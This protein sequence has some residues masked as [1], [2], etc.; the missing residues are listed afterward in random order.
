ME[1][2]VTDHHS[3]RR[4]AEGND[5]LPPAFAVINPKRQGD[6]PAFVELAGVG[7][8]Y[9][10]AQ[11]LLLEASPGGDLPGDP[12]LLDLVAIGTV[13]DV[14]PL[15][16]GGENRRLVKEGLALLGRP[17]RPGIQA[18]MAEAR[19][20]P[21]HV[22]AVDIGFV[23]GPRIN[24]AGRLESAMLAYDL[25]TAPD[26]LTARELAAALGALNR[27]RQALTHELAAR[28]KEKIA[29]EG[30][31]R[32][33]YLVSDPEFPSGIVGLVA[34]RLVEEL[35]RPVMLVEEDQN[36]SGNSRGSARSIPE[37]NVTAALDECREL[38]VRHG[39]H[40]MAAG[41]T[42][43]NALLP[44]LRARLEAI[45]QRELGG[46]DLVPTLRIDAVVQLSDLDWAMLALL[47]ELEPHGE[48]NPQPIF[49]SY[50]LEIKDVR[51]VGRESQHL[52]LVVRDLGASG[53]SA[54]AFWDAI[55]FNLGYWASQLPDRVDLA[56]TF[57]LNEFNGDQR[58]QLNIMT[59][60]WARTLT[61]T[62]ETTTPACGRHLLFPPHEH[63]AASV[64][65]SPW[66]ASPS[67]SWASSADVPL[68]PAPI[69]LALGIR[70]GWGGGWAATA[71]MDVEGISPPV[72]PMR[73]PLPSGACAASRHGRRFTAE[74]R[75]GA[76]SS[77]NPEALIPYL[78]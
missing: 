22:R 28:A 65:S 24:A 39:G 29:V 46:Q 70:A 3:I 33:L 19:L 49:A 35:Y 13:A 31:N 43:P 62:K 69:L 14:M 25:L 71:V 47:S 58:L 73:K 68:N 45:A 53:P 61:L 72:I 63:A 16:L 38:L 15:P 7:V 67:P 59:C 17:R 56:Y 41:F 11:A 74:C 21:D 12:E 6:P 10:L 42:V 18:M 44:Q 48:Q 32:D 1:V 4:D 52:K 57:E 26:A 2:I 40:A 50:G 36:D 20:I 77:R 54:R 76:P 55:G 34:G 30:A 5:E 60:A 9:K 75:A 23:L 37:F 78:Y 66:R 27:K 51:T 64:S 8:A